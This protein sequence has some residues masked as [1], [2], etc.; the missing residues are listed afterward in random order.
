M[1]LKAL[2]RG[3]SLQRRYMFRKGKNV[4]KVDPKKSWN[5]IEAEAGVE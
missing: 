4:I 5:E 3:K 1:Q 2:S